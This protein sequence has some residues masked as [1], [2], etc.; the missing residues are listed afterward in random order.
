MHPEAARKLDKFVKDQLKKN[1]QK[2][3]RDKQR[4]IRIQ[5]EKE[6]K[7]KEE[8]EKKKKEAQP[9]APTPAPQP[10]ANPTA[11]FGGDQNQALA[12]LLQ[13]FMS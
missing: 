6:K 11:A 9:P 5:N 2:I 12:S 8:E 13:L 3:Q 7:K 10:A 1:R 4:L